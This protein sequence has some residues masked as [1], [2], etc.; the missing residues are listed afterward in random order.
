MREVHER[1][2]GMEEGV[3]IMTGLNPQRVLEAIPLAIAMDKGAARSIQLVH[4][5]YAPGL[6][7][8]VVKIILSY[9]DFIKRRT[10]KI[11]E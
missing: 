10:W 3:A 11:N 5:Y 7:D 6:S 9:T 2:E 4:D 1:P 8:K